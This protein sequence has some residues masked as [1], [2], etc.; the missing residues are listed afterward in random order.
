MSEEAN[1]GAR[2]PLK[3]TGLNGRSGRIWP[4]QPVIP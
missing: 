4:L 3:H 2:Y 1:Q